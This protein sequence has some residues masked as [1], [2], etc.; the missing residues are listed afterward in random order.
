MAIVKVKIHP[1]I[2]IARVGNSPDEFFIGPERR[3]DRTPPE[4]GY[5]DALCRVKRQ[6]ARFRI[7]GYDEKGNMVKEITA[8]DAKIEW[9]VALA[10][11]KA[12]AE[13]FPG[14]GPRN[15]EVT[16]DDRKK[17]IISPEPRTLTG[18]N[19]RAEF[20]DGTFQLPGSEPVHVYLGEIRTDADG[21]LIILGGHGMSCSPTN[22]QISDAFNN[23]GWYDDVSD[24]PVK[25]KVKLDGASES[26]EAEGAWVIVAPPDFAPPVGNIITLYDRLFDLFV[27][28]GQLSA[29]E[30][31]SFNNDIY[32]ILQSTLDMEW[33][34]EQ[35]SSFHGWDPSEYPLTL[36]KRYSIFD[37]LQNPA[38]GGGNMPLL[39]GDAT[40]TPTQY[41]NMKKWKDDNFINDWMGHPPTPESQ[42]TPDGLDRAALENCVGAAFFPGIEAGEFLLKGTREEENTDHYMAPFRLDHSKVSAGDVTARMALPWQTDFYDCSDNWWPAQRPNQVIPEGETEYREWVRGVEDQSEMIY[43]WHAL[44]FVVVQGERMVEIERFD[45]SL[46]VAP[47]QRATPSEL[48]SSVL[49]KTLVERVWAC[50]LFSWTEGGEAN[51]IEASWATEPLVVGRYA[52]MKGVIRLEKLPLP[53]LQDLEA[54]IESEHPSVVCGG[55]AAPALPGPPQPLR[56]VLEVVFAVK[57]AD[58]FK[59]DL[60]FTVGNLAT[61]GSCRPANLVFLNGNSQRRLDFERLSLA[62]RY[63]QGLIA[64]SAI[65]S[66]S[67]GKVTGLE[68]S[69]VWKVSGAGESITRP[70]Y[71]FDV[72]LLYKYQNGGADGNSRG[73]G[74]PT[75]YL[76]VGRSKEQ[77][78]GPIEFECH[79]QFTYWNSIRK[80][81]VGLPEGIE[82]RVVDYDPVSANDVIGRG[83]TGSDGKV[84]IISVN[85]DESSPD[86]FFELHTNGQYIELETNRLVT[87][88]QRSS[89]KSYMLL[90]RVWSSQNHYSADHRL[91]YFND[92]AGSSIGSADLPITFRLSLDCF[93]KFVY[94][95]EVQ[96]KYMGLPEGIIVEAI[97]YDP[98][99]HLGIPVIGPIV[100]LL[101]PD[102]PLG[103]GVT[104]HD[105]K[106]FLRL[107]YKDE[108]RP[109]IYFR[110]RIPDDKP[111]RID[112]ATNQLVPP[113]I[114][115]QQ[116]ELTAAGPVVNERPIG[117]KMPRAEEID[118][119]KTLPIPRQWSTRQRYAL[120][121]PRRKGYWDDFIEHRIGI[122]ENPYVFDIFQEMPRFIAGNRVDYLINGDQALRRIERAIENAEKSIHVEVMLFYNDE[123]GS[124]IKNLLIRKA[125][126][127]VK[128]RLMFDVDT[129]ANSYNLIVLKKIW[130]DQLIHMDDGRRRELLAKLD[131]EIEAERRRGNTA[132]MRRELEATTNLIFKDSSFPYVQ[133]MP[134]AA[135]AVP[136][137][138]R[139]VEGRLPFFTIARIDHRKMI[140]VDGKVGFLGGMNIGQEYL[141]DVPF[142]PAMEAEEEA[143]TARTESWIKWHDCF[144]E[145]RGPAVREL[146]KLFRE[147]W[148][149]E[150]GDEFPIGPHELG[151]GTDPHHPYFPRIEPEPEDMLVKVVST[152][153]GARFH[154]HE[155]YLTA[156]DNARQEIYVEN[157]YLSSLEIKRHLIDAA[158]RGARVHYVFP[159]EHNDSFE[160]VYSG[161][162]KYQDFLEAG[163]KVYEYRNHMTH[164]KVAAIDDTTVIGS[165][166][167]NHSSMFNHYECNVF[168]KNEA[169]TENFK[170]DFFQ[171]DIANSWT[172]TKADLDNLIRIYPGAYLYLWSI[173]NVWF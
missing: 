139:G 49:Q 65:K 140:I 160:F 144:C 80:A 62:Q 35:A 93:V 10:N 152:T 148:V 41:E 67:S 128:V 48:E 64:F 5:K 117:T 74:G 79:L 96:Q 34:N 86:V 123:I 131:S 59:D 66:P 105:G 11:K 42:I 116:I 119:V 8:A 23:D 127:G 30:R 38:G 133:L 20:D 164:A 90:P 53:V 52:E 51:G 173:V 7:F 99:A 63:R 170:R 142:D 125:K 88:E 106:V 9:T 168:I 113:P 22:V 162:I 126:E 151:A 161:R 91:G 134:S 19:Q 43:R 2:G 72:G 73:S 83:T 149:T 92:F 141:Y 166:N 158:R 26:L 46:V 55:S 109:D 4:G 82:V 27:Q 44:G 39:L 3:W 132:D 14:G 112:L 124:R 172:I 120:E 87:K 29:P 1:A 78:A 95:N 84:Q 154:L 102:D 24:G 108:P 107:Y 54:R 33:V 17:L 146:Q 137:A 104:D 28:K 156:I 129:T 36:S 121:D 111:N 163:V 157:P 167:F 155:E 130:I 114:A 16:G 77:D 58:I 122:A 68:L 138:Y 13:K 101:A 89:G 98:E 56:D 71:Y 97:D 12:A 85:K 76:L 37:K 115:E 159:D 171:R 165:A 50:R 136:P 75:T 169:F 94:W 118:G 61:T 25:A 143:R 21:R 103:R 150:G 57:E 47:V 60:V 31:P 18:P 153:P 45:P 40:L 100:S 70:E 145:V 110:Y 69:A 15:P 147:R 81:Y 6:A 32:P 135:A